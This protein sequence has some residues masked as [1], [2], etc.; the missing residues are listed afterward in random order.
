MEGQDSYITKCIK[1]IKSGKVR[2]TVTQSDGMEDEIR[3]SIKQ[4]TTRDWIDYGLFKYAM[5]NGPCHEMSYS[6]MKPI[7]EQI[8]EEYDI[9][10]KA[11]IITLELLMYQ[12]ELIRKG[13]IQ[14]SDI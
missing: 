12:D 3:D 1:M 7:A 13:I 8:K 10:L 9:D 5:N 11:S 14:A 4:W 6:E 2:P